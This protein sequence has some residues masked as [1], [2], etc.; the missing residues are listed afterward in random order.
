MSGVLPLVFESSCTRREEEDDLEDSGD[1]LNSFVEGVLYD[2]SRSVGDSN[3]EDLWPL[4]GELSTSTRS[5]T[6]VSHWRDFG[7]KMP[8]DDDA[9]IRFDGDVSTSGRRD[10]P[11]VCTGKAVREAARNV[12]I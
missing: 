1:V 8:D 10:L 3:P 4:E 2:M 12:Y 11:N 9:L 6:G 5:R 7:V